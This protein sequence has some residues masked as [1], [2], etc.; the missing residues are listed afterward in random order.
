MP[1]PDCQHVAIDFLPEKETLDTQVVYL[2]GAGAAGEG[3]VKSI[4]YKAIFQENMM[5]KNLICKH[6]LANVELSVK[7]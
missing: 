5:H 7:M 2:P 1:A 6:F 4:W 3:E